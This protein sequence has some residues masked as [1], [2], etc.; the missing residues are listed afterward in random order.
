MD[1]SHGGHLTHGS[2]PSFSGKNYNAFSYGVELDGYI[3][4]DKV[5]DIAKL[6][7]QK[8]SFVVQVLMLENLILKNLEK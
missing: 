5:M 6:Y 4:Y 3:D 1:L 7:N 2:K 8:L